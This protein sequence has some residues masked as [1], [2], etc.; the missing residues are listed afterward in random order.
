M[1]RMADV[2]LN[3]MTV[4]GDRQVPMMIGHPTRTS[5]SAASMMATGRLD[6]AGQLN[7]IFRRRWPRQLALGLLVPYGFITAMLAFFQRSLIY[8]P[9]RGA[10]E[11]AEAGFEEQQ[12]LSIQRQ[13]D[14]GLTLHGWLI[15][16]DGVTSEAAAL[17]AGDDRPLILYF[18]GNGGHRGYRAKEIH[19][20]TELGCHVLYFDYRGYAENAGKPTEDDLAR[21]AQGVWEFAV[22]HLGVP[23]ER[24]VIWGESLGGGVAT[25]LTS[26][27]C[28]AGT[29]PRG[30]ILRGTFTSLVDAAS[31]H[32]PWLPV[33]WVL[34]DRFPSVERIGQVTCPL[35][36][37]HGRQ[38]TIVPFEQGQELFAAAPDQSTSG[39]RKTFV[40][41][42]QAGHNDIMYVAADDVR[43]A[44]EQFLARLK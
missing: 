39:V 9:T 44:V 25:R 35:L 27:S 19:Q 40:E 38:D 16:A 41:L 24:I 5:I 10:V 34:I 17:P 11:V 42:S 2:W 14:D 33:R 43:D 4:A 20:F 3:S 6:P 13:T 22:D 7:G 1:M 36:V 29:P 12:L 21:D 28:A 32:Y 30:L 18:P 23:P 26:E 37:I 15:L 8:L 31:Y